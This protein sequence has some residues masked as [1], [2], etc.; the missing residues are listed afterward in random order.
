MKTCSTRHL[1]E[2]FTAQHTMTGSHTFLKYKP[3]MVGFT[4]IPCNL[5]AYG[6]S[7]LLNGVVL[8]DGGHHLADLWAVLDLG[9][10]LLQ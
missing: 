5:A 9:V 3:T 8:P 4:V 10:V 6:K 2:A 1:G 7:D